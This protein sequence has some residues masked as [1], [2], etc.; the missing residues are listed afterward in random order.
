M[1]NFTA[2]FEISETLP[3][4]HQR[5]RS[6]CFRFAVDVVAIVPSPRVA[7]VVNAPFRSASSRRSVHFGFDDPF[8]FFTGQKFL[9]TLYE[10]AHFLLRYVLSR[11]IIGTRDGR[12]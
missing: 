2:N 6:D 1:K 5:H 12:I 4:R 7:P 8:E 9:D 3:P 11:L 10:I